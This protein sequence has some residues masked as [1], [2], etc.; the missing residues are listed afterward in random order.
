MDNW[1][2]VVTGLFEGG[3][4][5]KE[6]DVCGDLEQVRHFSNDDG[7]TGRDDG[8]DSDGELRPDDTVVFNR[9]S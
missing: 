6:E 3:D 7:E 4:G 5:E 9:G 2:M 1:R 8:V